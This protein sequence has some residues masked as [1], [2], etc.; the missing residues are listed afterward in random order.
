MVRGLRVNPL[1]GADIR[2]VLQHT[3]FLS[4][5]MRSVRQ[6]C[7]PGIIHSTDLLFAV[8]LDITKSVSTWY[9]SGF[10]SVYLNESS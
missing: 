7:I 6:N 5:C 3:L 2:F 10:L 9:S 8:S 1:T 4:V